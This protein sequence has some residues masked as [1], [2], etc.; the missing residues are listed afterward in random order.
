M[1]LTENN[2]GILGFNYEPTISDCYSKKL[3]KI[4][5]NSEDSKQITV[6]VWFKG[7]S[8]AYNHVTIKEEIFSSNVLTDTKEIT[9]M[10]NI[11]RLKP[12]VK[13]L[14]LIEKYN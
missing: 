12:L 7:D 9:V 3:D 1:K 6:Y 4:A 13:L 5:K 8:W 2:I 14:L 11:S 10:E